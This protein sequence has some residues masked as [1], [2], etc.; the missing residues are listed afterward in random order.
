MDALQW[1]IVIK[2]AVAGS[3]SNCRPLGCLVAL[4]AAAEDRGGSPA[5]HDL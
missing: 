5:T 4:V 2:S 3:S 1:L